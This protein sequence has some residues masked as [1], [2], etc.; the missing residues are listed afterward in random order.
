MSTPIEV[1]PEEFQSILDAIDQ[2]RARRAALMPDQQTAI[3][4][5]YEAFDRLRELGWREGIYSPKDGSEFEIIE[6]GSTG[7]FQC[8][9]LGEW[10]DGYWITT[11]DRDAYPSSAPPMLFRLFP[12]AEAAR[13]ARIAAA[14]AKYKAE[15]DH[16]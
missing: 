4:A 6:A 3:R 1:S 5:L 8:R 14:A 9:Y 7:I 11:D 12:A 2:A 16:D 10:P 15:R 13:K